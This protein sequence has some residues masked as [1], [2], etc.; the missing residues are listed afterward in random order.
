MK[1]KKLANF[2]TAMILLGNVGTTVSYANPTNT[3]LEQNAETN[4]ENL[5]IEETN[6]G[7]ITE[8]ARFNFNNYVKIEQNGNDEKKP[9]RYSMESRG[10][11]QSNCYSIIT[12]LQDTLEEKYHK[13]LNMT[14]EIQYDKEKNLYFFDLLIRVNGEGSGILLNQENY[15]TRD[16]WRIYI[17]PSFYYFDTSD[18]NFNPLIKE[19]DDTRYYKFTDDDFNKMKEYIKS[20]DSNISDISMID[21]D[22]NVYYY[23]P[24]QHM[25]YVQYINVKVTY[26]NGTEKLSKIIYNRPETANVLNKHG[27]EEILINKDEANN[28]KLNENNVQLVNQILEKFNEN[29]VLNSEMFFTKNKIYFDLNEKKY[30]V[31]IRDK[32]H[33]FCSKDDPDCE[34]LTPGVPSPA[35]YHEYGPTIIYLRLEDDAKINNDLEDVDLSKIDTINEIHYNEDSFNPNDWKFDQIAINK[36]RCNVDG[37]SYFYLSENEYHD[38]DKKDVSKWL[39]SINKDYDISYFEEKEQDGYKYWIFNMKNNDRLIFK[40]VPN[41][42]PDA[43]LF[44]NILETRELTSEDEMIVKNVLYHYMKDQAE[45]VKLGKQIIVDD[46]GKATLDIYIGKNN[47]YVGDSYLDDPENFTKKTIRLNKLD[48]ETFDIVNPSNIKSE[49][50]EAE[51]C[52]DCIEVEPGKPSPEFPPND[53]GPKPE[54]KPEK[55]KKEEKPKYKPM[56]TKPIPKKPKVK[57]EEPKIDQNEKKEVSTPSNLPKEKATPSNL[58]KEKTSSSNLPKRNNENGVTGRVV[59]KEYN[60]NNNNPENKTNVT[61]V[62]ERPSEDVNKNEKELKQNAYNNNDNTAGLPKTNEEKREAVKTGDNLFGKITLF[63]AILSI[64]GLSYLPFLKKKKIEINSEN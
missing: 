30:Y 33:M 22:K 48:N 56:V 17:K 61:I 21:D 4:I 46:N 29:K 57:D 58:P 27:V 34:P 26:K 13:Q 2:M 45:N 18:E 25:N 40:L 14:T 11:D 64:F 49:K 31:E 42:I 32:R 41:K 53:D 1:Q 8:I 51:P 15:K 7:K 12:N 28:L 6:S 37:K 44:E 9:Y 43:I 60:N 59:S 62:N 24:E 39:K 10:I 5:N 16:K 20:F 23:H 19:Y 36:N 52:D 63:T 35:I 55:P 47:Y 38:D 3:T 50:C 54:P